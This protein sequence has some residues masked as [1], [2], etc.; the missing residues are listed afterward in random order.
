LAR[1]CQFDEFAYPGEHENFEKL[2]KL[3]ERREVNDDE[4]KLETFQ[5]DVT[6]A[7]VDKLLRKWDLAIHATF[8]NSFHVLRLDDLTSQTRRYAFQNSY[9]L[10]EEP[11]VACIYVAGYNGQYY[12]G[13][14]DHREPVEQR[15]TSSR[16]S[17][18]DSVRGED[19]TAL[20]TPLPQ[21]ALGTYLETIRLMPTSYGLVSTSENLVEHQLTLTQPN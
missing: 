4:F 21:A 10:V 9:R 12:T 11:I 7:W 17:A 8:P 5:F 20:R 13:L 3:V 15:T 2:L 16:P 18:T 1:G 14:T 19:W 6:T